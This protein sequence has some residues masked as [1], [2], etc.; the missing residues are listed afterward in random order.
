MCSIEAIARNSLILRVLRNA[1]SRANKVV[2]GILEDSAKVHWVETDLEEGGDTKF[3]DKRTHQHQRSNQ[4][5]QHIF[6]QIEAEQ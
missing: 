3:Q 5:L 1:V 4:Q 6:Q 2:I